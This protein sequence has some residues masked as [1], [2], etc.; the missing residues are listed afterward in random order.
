MYVKGTILS[1]FYNNLA[2][3]PNIYFQ[4]GKLFFRDRFPQLFWQKCNLLVPNYCCS[5]SNYRWQY[6]TR[7][8][9]NI[10]SSIL[11]LLVVFSN[12]Q[13]SWGD[14][15]S[16]NAAG[17]SQQCVGAAPKHILS[18]Q[19]GTSQIVLRD[20]PST[21]ERVQWS[22]EIRSP[23]TGIRNQTFK[24]GHIIDKR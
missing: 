24:N 2:K 10:A 4:L 22:L 16:P 7:C 13:I 23:P 18:H 15:W 11:V 9:F 12:T 1:G 8:I 6:C 20:G 17:R 19:D 5:N 3:G 14:T 21:V